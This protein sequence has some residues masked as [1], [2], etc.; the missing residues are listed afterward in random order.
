MYRDL[1][2]REIKVSRFTVILCKCLI[3]FVELNVF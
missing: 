2:D 3:L 1:K